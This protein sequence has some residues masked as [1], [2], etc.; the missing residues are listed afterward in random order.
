[1]SCR[2][3]YH[4]YERANGHERSNK[5]CGEYQGSK[6]SQPADSFICR[7]RAQRYCH[8]HRW[9][10]ASGIHSQMVPRR[11]PSRPFLHHPISRGAR[12]HIG[13]QRYCVLVGISSGA[14]LGLRA[15]GRRACG[16]QRRY[17]PACASSRRSFRLGLRTYHSGDEFVRRG[18]GWRKKCFA[19]QPAQFH[20]GCGW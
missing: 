7:F 1:M 2:M 14:R 9:A 10:Y 8:N 12:R 11:R 5:C 19:S 18:T 15:D 3:S 16:S 20:L 4:L 6:A 17:A 13:F